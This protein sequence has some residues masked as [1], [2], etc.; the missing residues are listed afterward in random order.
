MQPR[1]ANARRVTAV[2]VQAACLRV[3]THANL[4]VWAARRSMESGD[5]DGPGF[6]VREQ[7]YRLQG[8]AR[9]NAGRHGRHGGIPA[10]DPGKV[11][12][13]GCYFGK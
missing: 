3:R 9:I 12:A 13:H 5:T 4:P 11:R 2:Q 8:I 10:M 1:I 7:V 6:G